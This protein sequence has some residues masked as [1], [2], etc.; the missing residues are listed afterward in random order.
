MALKYISPELQYFIFSL[1]CSVNARPS[2]P[3]DSEQMPCL[4]SVYLIIV[5]LYNPEEHSATP[6]GDIPE[7]LIKLNH[8]QLLLQLAFGILLEAHQRD[9]IPLSLMPLIIL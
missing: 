7:I 5:T 1:E 9:N 4:S 2:S 8:Y 6:L 3:T